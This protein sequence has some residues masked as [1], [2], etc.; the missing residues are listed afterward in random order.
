L[1]PFVCPAGNANSFNGGYTNYRQCQGA[2]HYSSDGV[3]DADKFTY[4][5]TN[6][7]DTRGQF[8]FASGEIEGRFPPDGFSNTVFYSE[9]LAGGLIKGTSD[10][11]FGVTFAGGYPAQ[12]G[13]T[14]AVVPNHTASAA[15]G[16]IPAWTAAYVASGH[17]GG[18]C[19]ATF[20]DGG[21]KSVTS[22]V[23]DKVWMCL[24][25]SNDNRAVTLP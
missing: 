9:A 4:S 3:L 7:S 15:P 1:A 12:T 25:A 16:S 17:P 11:H 23:G 14:T 5:T 10:P 24:G 6:D 2:S 19:N 13:F 8:A 20:G 21:V 18:A 22:N